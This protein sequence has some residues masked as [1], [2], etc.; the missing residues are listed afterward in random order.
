MCGVMPENRV[1]ELVQQQSAGS[2]EE[3]IVCCFY[4]LQSINVRRIGQDVWPLTFA[5]CQLLLACP[6]QQSESELIFCVILDGIIRTSRLLKLC[7]NR[8][9]GVAIGP[10]SLDGT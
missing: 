5:V 6:V 10:K 2:H 7:C 3:E 4:M 9:V 1:G 8:R